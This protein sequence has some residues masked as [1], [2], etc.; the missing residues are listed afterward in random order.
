V[1]H[2]RPQLSLSVGQTKT[3]VGSHKSIGAEND[4]KRAD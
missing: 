1:D 4:E 2:E 3:V